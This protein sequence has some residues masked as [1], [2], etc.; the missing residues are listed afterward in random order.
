MHDGTFRLFQV[1]RCGDAEPGPCR[2][3]RHVET[4]FE[5]EDDDPV[6]HLGPFEL[7]DICGLC[8]RRRLVAVAVDLL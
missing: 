3:A 7:E 1:L 5:D 6:T 4:M 8:H 2:R